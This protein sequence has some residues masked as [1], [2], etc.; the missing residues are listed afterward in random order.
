MILSNGIITLEVAGHGA[1]PV[2]LV[3][4]GRDCIH[5]I[6]PGAR[7]QFKYIIRIL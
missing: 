1:E 5:R 2:S 7:Y 4:D 6:A 3:K